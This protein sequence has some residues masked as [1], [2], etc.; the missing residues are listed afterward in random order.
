MSTRITRRELIKGAA[1]GAAVV[2][3]SRTFDLPY[4]MAQGAPAGSKAKLRLAIIGCGGKGVST[5]VTNGAREKIVALVDPDESKIASAIKKAK[6][7]NAPDTDSIKTFSDYRKMFDEMGKEIDAVFVVTPNHHHALP[8]LL[9]MQRGIAAYVEKPMAYDI[10]ETRKMAE[11]ARKY[12]VATQMG[13]Q[14]HSGEGYRRLVEY[15]QAGAIGNVTEV[16]HW[17]D[18]ANGGVGPRPA[19]ITVPKGMNWDAWIGPAPYRDYH[20]QLH[21]HSWHGWHDFGDGSLGN[22]GAHIMDGAHWALNLEA[23]TAIEMEEMNGGSDERYPIG[24]R[25]RWDFPA[26]GEMPPVKVFWYDGK[27]TGAKGTA[28]GEAPDSVAEDLRNRPPLLNELRK[29]YGKDRFDSNGTLYVG[30]K[31]IMYTG[32]YGGGVRIVPE[33]QHKATPV[34]E[35]KIARIK[36]SHT[37]DFLRG[38]R[39]PSHTPCS[40][41]EVASKLNEHLLL[42]CLAIKAGVGKKVEWDAANMKSTNLPEVNRFLQRDYRKGWEY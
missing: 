18:R 30:D 8:A 13:N 42:G 10:Y 25:I 6:E 19:A 33:E 15:I 24:T 37:E 34:P 23:P 21:P 7:H 4:I 38:V 20:P 3:G 11:F 32:T 31:G 5:H 16:Y 35:M 12:K 41:F 40:N 39:D 2:A 27:R 14:G 36:G 1:A 17:S 9:A 22:M 29:K 28:K 26:R